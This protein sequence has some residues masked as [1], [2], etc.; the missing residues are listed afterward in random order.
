M[1]VESHKFTFNNAACVACFKKLPK[2]G[3]AFACSDCLSAAS[4]WRGWKRIANDWRKIAKSLAAE[5]AGL[6]GEIR[7]IAGKTKR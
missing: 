7:A 1:K 4:A 3:G 6:K 2:H 5:L